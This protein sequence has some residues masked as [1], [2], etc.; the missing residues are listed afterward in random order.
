MP[1]P[2]PQQSMPSTRT[3]TIPVDQ[4]KMQQA[5]AHTH[6]ILYPIPNHYIENPEQEHV[7]FDNSIAEDYASIAE[8][9]PKPVLVPANIPM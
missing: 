5:A 3:Q 1:Q 2:I 9:Q 6:P 7:K 8:I 4:N